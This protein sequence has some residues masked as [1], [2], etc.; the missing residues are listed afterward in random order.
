MNLRDILE[1]R[2]AVRDFD[3]AKPLDT[4]VVRDCIKLAQL[5]PTSSNLQLWE[6]YHII[7]PTKY[8]EL[9]SACL[10]QGTA[11][12][13]QQF[14]VFTVRP[15]WVKEHAEAVYAFEA[16]NIAK[17]ST[18]DRKTA[19]V[20]QLEGYYKKAIPLLYGRCFG[21]LGAFRK[22]SSCLIGLAR[23][24]VR[25]VS[26]RDVYTVQQKSCS[27]VAQ[28]FMLAMSEAGYDTCPMEGIDSK[29]IKQIL[30][31]PKA[32]KVNMIISCGV[33][34]DKGV[35]GERFRMPFERHY[36]LL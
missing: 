34:S 32:A 25:E 19:R 35:R 29:R 14:V 31:I 24:I 23:P 27:L 7:D 30:G 3:P 11:R 22:I 10:G 17:N 13:A 26:E 18:D 9:V 6:A 4:E 5:A 20:K 36:R 28:T 15:D 8:P 21:L 16:D 33:R 12:T 2:R 1:H